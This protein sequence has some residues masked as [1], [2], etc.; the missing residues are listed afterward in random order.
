MEL[1]REDCLHFAVPDFVSVSIMT[2]HVLESE[3]GEK[4]EVIFYFFISTGS[5]GFL[6]VLIKFG[7]G[8]VIFFAIYG[9][10]FLSK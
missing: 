7:I 6:L 1:G 8:N 2:R 3:R 5:R 9:H 10:G 4:E